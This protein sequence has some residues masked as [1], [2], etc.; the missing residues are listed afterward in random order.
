[1]GNKFPYADIRDKYK[2]E[3][4]FHNGQYQEYC[5]YSDGDTF[6]FFR[7]ME[8]DDIDYPGWAVPIGEYFGYSEALCCDF[9]GSMT[10]DVDEPDERQWSTQCYLALKGKGRW[11]I[12]AV[13]LTMPSRATDRM[14][15]AEFPGVR[16]MVGNCR[17]MGDAIVK[18]SYQIGV[19]PVDWYDL[20]EKRYQRIAPI[21]SFAPPS[22]DR[23]SELQEGQIFVFGSNLQGHHGGGAAEIAAR[24]FGA[25][26]GQGVGLQGRSYAIPTM[27]GPVES[28]KPYVDE[29]LKFAD[30]HPE[31]IFLVT[32]IGCGIAGFTDEQI[33]PLFKEA[34]K[35]YNVL[36]PKSFLDIL[37]K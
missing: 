21:G 25:V 14:N 37:E 28:I 13:N 12:Y 22:P 11:S 31:M 30:K 7:N 8:G 17:T 1:M 32:R 18:L 27:Q 29:F 16:L 3:V 23:I 2:V 36:L 26:W 10:R 19:S 20:K 33:A 24:K 6:G 35:K 5:L 9:L 34:E 4:I 15:G